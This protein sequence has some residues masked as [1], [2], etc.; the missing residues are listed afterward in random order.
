MNTSE[1][2]IKYENYCMNLLKE[3]GYIDVKNTKASGDQ[4]IDIIAYRDGIKYGFQCKYY[5]SPV[6]NH[7]V[8]EASSGAKYY[9]CHVAI[10]VTNTCF[11]ESAKK[12]A[13][14]IGVVLWEKIDMYP[15]SKESN[16]E[17]EEYDM[18][19]GE[20]D[21]GDLNGF[22]SGEKNNDDHSIVIPS[23]KFVFYISKGSSDVYTNLFIQYMPKEEFEFTIDLP[24]TAKTVSSSFRMNYIEGTLIRFSGCGIAE[25]YKKGDLYCNVVIGGKYLEYMYPDIYLPI[26]KKRMNSNVITILRPNMKPIETE[27]N[28]MQKT[29]R[30]K[31][32]GYNWMLGLNGSIFID[33]IE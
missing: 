21:A 13:D 27:L 25:N 12:L 26:L 29:I 9:E 23:N 14:K 15:D 24:Y 3:K 4:G 32:A 1:L 2:G 11:T 31:N 22:T 5:S 17:P 18:Y 30:L 20:Y 19:G 16:S 10:V 8:Q 33:M 28:F 6:G 7:A